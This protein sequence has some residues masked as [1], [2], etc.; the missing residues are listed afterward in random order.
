[1]KIKQEYELRRM[2][3]RNIVVDTGAGAP[4]GRGV[5]TLNDSGALL[6][7]LLEDGAGEQELLAAVRE[8]YEVGEEQAA[9]DV[10]EFIEGLRRMRVLEE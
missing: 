4:Q 7:K 3:G 10:A 2:A 5:F 1:M 8:E 9:A 6:W